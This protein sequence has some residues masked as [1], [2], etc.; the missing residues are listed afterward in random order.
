MCTSTQVCY[1]CHEGLRPLLT[2]T[3]DIHA[4]RH[5]DTQ[6]IKLTDSQMGS[7]GD[8]KAP[9]CWAAAGMTTLDM[10]GVQI[11]FIISIA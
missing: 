5:T 10:D 1:L 9:F 2:Q 7:Y 3:E 11:D 8:L 6:T 4:D